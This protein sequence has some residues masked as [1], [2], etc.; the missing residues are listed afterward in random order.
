MKLRISKMGKWQQ[1]RTRVTTG[2]WKRRLL[3]ASRKGQAG[4][5]GRH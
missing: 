2:S 1:G 4:R 5:Q 3:T